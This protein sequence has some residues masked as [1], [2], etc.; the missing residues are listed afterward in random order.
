MVAL[1]I[2]EDLA[3]MAQKV[4]G[5]N[6]RVTRFIRME[7]EQHRM[8]QSRFTPATLDLVARAKE[9]ANRRKTTGFDREQVAADLNRSL[10]EMTSAS[11]D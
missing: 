2:P 9:A 6:D 10:D 11:P 1:Q 8:R 5:L 4:P 7:I 3:E